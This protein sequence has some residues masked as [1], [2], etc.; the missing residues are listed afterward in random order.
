M[1]VREI[2]L[3]GNPKLYEISFPVKKEEID[4]MKL[5]VED[6]RDTLLDFRQRYNTGRAIS[7]PQVGVMKRLVYMHIDKP[8]VIINPIL[9]M[10]SSE[11]MEVVDDCMCFPDLLVKVKRHRQCR[12]TYLNINWQEETI[13]FENSLSELLQHECDHLDGIVAISR[14]IDQTSLALRSQKHFLTEKLMR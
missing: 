4:N 1:A 14:A 5:L 9:D 3:L 10:K 2:L 12:I 8:F 6:L 13:M 7:A 11:M